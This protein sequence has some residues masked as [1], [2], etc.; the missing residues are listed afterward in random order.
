MASKAMFSF[1]STNFPMLTEM[2]FCS[3]LV[4]VYHSV[5]R[6]SKL[7]FVSNC[8]LIYYTPQ[9]Y[10]TVYNLN[11]RNVLF[12]RFCHPCGTFCYLFLFSI[13]ARLPSPLLFL[14]WKTKI[15]CKDDLLWPVV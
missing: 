14:C 4:A 10:K 2:I 8:Y 6:G 1:S 11:I 13:P 5:Y 3:V 7:T 12:P 15:I 9:G